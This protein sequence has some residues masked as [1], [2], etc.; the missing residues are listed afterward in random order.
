M[1][2]TINKLHK[3]LGKA[4]EE[5]MGRRRVCINKKTFI[6]PL[7]GDGCVILPIENADIEV[8]PML[9]EDGGMA[10]RKDGTE[11]ERLYMVLKGEDS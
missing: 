3:M 5:G 2:I 4:I 11:I 1:P 10:T 6:H 8:V 9:D 7:E